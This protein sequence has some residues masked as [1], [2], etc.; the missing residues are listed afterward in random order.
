MEA[1]TRALL[2]EWARPGLEGCLPDWI[3]ARWG[4][5]EAHLL[6]LAPSAEIGWFDMHDKAPALAASAA[7]PRLRW[8]SSAYAGVDWMPLGGLAQR[9]VVLTCGAGRRRT[10]WRSSPS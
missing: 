9:G 1:L 10:R 2:P 5:D 4:Q 3:D 7:A 6:A 8:L